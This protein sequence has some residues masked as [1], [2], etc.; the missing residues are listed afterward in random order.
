MRILIAEDEV[1]LNNIIKKVLEKEGMIVDAAFDGEE[2]LLFLDTVK[3]DAVV[4]DIMMPKKSGLEVVKTMRAKKIST[5]VLFLTAMDS[6]ENRVT[7][8]DAGADDYLVKPFSFEELLA[9]IRAITR[10]YDTDRSPVLTLGDLSVNTVSR[11]ITRGEKDISLSQKEYSLLLYFLKHPGQILS[12]E[13]IEENLYDF[14]FEGESNV[15]DVYISFLRKKIDA[16]FDKKLIHTV[17]G[18]GWCIKEE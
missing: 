15:I 9:R 17:R 10:K 14:D 8:L 2:A 1:A 6:V 11:K 13:Q 5:P 7:G 4:S 18:A 3:Y 16:D 12:R